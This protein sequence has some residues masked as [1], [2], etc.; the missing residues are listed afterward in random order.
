VTPA[1]VHGQFVVVN[2]EQHSEATRLF[3]NDVLWEGTSVDTGLHC[4][5]DDLR[6]DLCVSRVF[7]RGN[8]PH[9]VLH[10]DENSNSIEHI[11]EAEVVRRRPQRVVLVG[12]GVPD[13]EE[14][15]HLA[16]LGLLNGG[17]L[18]QVHFETSFPLRSQ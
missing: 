11:M 18:R 17:Q 10:V 15:L 5:G 3:T 6:S 7:M 1:E 8:L 16:H 14:V 12:H 2:S 13:R 9:T 4:L